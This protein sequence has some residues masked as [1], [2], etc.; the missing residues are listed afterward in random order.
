MNK[1]GHCQFD[2]AE[3][4]Q[5]F[6]LNLPILSVLL[7]KLH[8]FGNTKL[9]LWRPLSEFHQEEGLY[10]LSQQDCYCLQLV[11]L[12]KVHLLTHS[13]FSFL[14]ASKQ[15]LQFVIFVLVI[16]HSKEKTFF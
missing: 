9:W 10:C 12:V 5:L 16:D 11:L 15:A 4:K 6:L 13:S 8:F 1:G 3:S 7:Q 14:F 2:Q